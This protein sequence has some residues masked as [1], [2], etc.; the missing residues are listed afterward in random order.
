MID[1]LI[2]FVTLCFI[3]PALVRDG[4]SVLM[5]FFLM[6]ILFI[7]LFF[8]EFFTF[9]KKTNIEYSKIEKQMEKDGI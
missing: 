7:V 3:I 4:V 1:I 8:C 5:S 6:G 2:I 9:H